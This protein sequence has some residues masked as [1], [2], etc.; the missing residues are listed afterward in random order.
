MF[1]K[2]FLYLNFSNLNSIF[3]SLA[4]IKLLFFLFQ[5]LLVFF[6]ALLNYSA[7]VLCCGLGIRWTYLNEQAMRGK[8]KERLRTAE[9]GNGKRTGTGKVEGLFGRETDEI[10]GLLSN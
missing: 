6:V 10:D 4:L 3:R 9:F 2:I 8:C 7:E 1:Q 5:F